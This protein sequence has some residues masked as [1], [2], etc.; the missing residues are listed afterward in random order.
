MYIDGVACDPPL[1]WTSG[2]IFCNVAAG[3]FDSLSLGS[4]V[5]ASA[6]FY[7]GD[8]WMAPAPVGVLVAGTG[9][10]KRKK[11]CV[12]LWGGFFFAFLVF[13]FHY[14]F[15]SGST[16]FLVLLFVS[17]PSFFLV[18]CLCCFFFCF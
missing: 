10:K 11:P 15:S 18:C 14:F 6:G 12:F 7:S 1:L 13:F 8:I 3:T 4:T 5:Y 9:K 17:F 2:E 16:L